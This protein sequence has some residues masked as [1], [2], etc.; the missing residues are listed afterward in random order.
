MEEAVFGKEKEIGRIR[1]EKK[2]KL[3]LEVL[4]PKEELF[5]PKLVPQGECEAYIRWLEGRENHP[6][7]T[8]V[9]ILKDKGFTFAD[10]LKER[11]RERQKEIEKE[12]TD[13]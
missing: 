1:F 3:P 8:S 4:P 9:G 5:P 7:H 6:A 2:G 10:F 12:S 11:E 13:N